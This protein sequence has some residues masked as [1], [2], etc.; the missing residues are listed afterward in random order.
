MKKIILF[1]TFVLSFSLIG[2]VNA[3]DINVY[4]VY[5]KTCPHCKNALAFF[6]EYLPSHENVKLY[7]YESSEETKKVQKIMDKLDRTISS[8]PFII[9][10][11][12]TITGFSDSLKQGIIDDIEYYE[13]NDY[14]D[15]IGEVFD[16]KSK[17]A[18]EYSG[19][20]LKVEDQTEDLIKNKDEKTVVNNKNKYLYIIGG[21]IILLIIIEF[22]KKLC[23]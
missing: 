17:D 1:I 14:Y 16:V 18:L 15:P 23:K 3:K 21:L 4:I 20:K 7:K 9:I 19:D 11:E 2:I 22:I 13:N 10:G 5:S 6:D 8:V 12:K